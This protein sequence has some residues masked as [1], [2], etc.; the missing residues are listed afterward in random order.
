MH[1][2][3][4]RRS[5]VNPGGQLQ[6]LNERLNVWLGADW[7]WVAGNTLE[8]EN[9]I[10]EKL[11]LFSSMENNINWTILGRNTLKKSTLKMGIVR[12]VFIDAEKYNLDNIRK[13]RM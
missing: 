13:E 3:E 12:M 6:L 9:R 5:L 8:N 4:W 10:W 11:E 2:G 7:S 1:V